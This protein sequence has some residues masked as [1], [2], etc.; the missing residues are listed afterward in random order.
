MSHS[1]FEDLGLFLHRHPFP[2]ISRSNPSSLPLQSSEIRSNRPLSSGDKGYQDQTWKLFKMGCRI[3]L[4]FQ[5]HSGCDTPARTEHGKIH[6]NVKVILSLDV[7][8]GWANGSC[9]LGYSFLFDVCGTLA[10]LIKLTEFACSGQWRA[11][12]AAL[13]HRCS[14]VRTHGSGQPVLFCPQ[15]TLKTGL[16]FFLVKA[17]LSLEGSKDSRH[18]LQ[19][20]QPLRWSL[21]P[22]LSKIRDALHAVWGWLGPCAC[23][24]DAL[25]IFSLEWWLT[26]LHGQDDKKSSKGNPLPLCF[27]NLALKKFHSSL[28]RSYLKMPYV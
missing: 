25:S 9:G 2:A 4:S 6:L 23:Q 20:N 15:P 28:K 21:L 18:L 3:S 8:W 22:P 11:R 16:H 13:S 12:S 24:D 1:I 5:S 26:S 17:P 19:Q 10:K 27:L 7:F 14:R